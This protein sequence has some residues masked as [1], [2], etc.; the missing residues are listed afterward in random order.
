M[1]VIFGHIFYDS[2]FCHERVIKSKNNK[3]KTPEK[4][5]ER[6]NNQYFVLLFEIP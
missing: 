3:I 1:V 4:K 2:R 5:Q 6:R